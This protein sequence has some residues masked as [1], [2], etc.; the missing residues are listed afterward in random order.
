MARMAYRCF[1][2]R[3]LKSIVGKQIVTVVVAT[4]ER[5]PLQQVYLVFSDGTSFEFFGPSLGC[6]KRVDTA[7]NIE[8]YVESRSGRIERV[9]GE[10]EQL[11]RFDESVEAAL[12][13]DLQAWREVKEVIDK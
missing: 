7:A 8:E 1:M 4:S 3:G 12:C 10:V 11:A 5:A 2:K 9:Y 6:C 13:R